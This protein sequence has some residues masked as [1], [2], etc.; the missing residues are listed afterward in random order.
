MGKH[1]RNTRPV[2]PRLKI[3]SSETTQFVLQFLRRHSLYWS[4]IC[5]VEGRAA[6]GVR[7]SKRATSSN[8]V[9]ADAPVCALEL[10]LCSSIML[11][12][13]LFIVED[14]VDMK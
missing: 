14:M 13:E 8:V 3:R 11:F 2:S 6:I 1:L 5:D 4:A 7:K 12:Y 10:N 9:C